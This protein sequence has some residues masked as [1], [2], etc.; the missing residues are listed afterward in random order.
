MHTTEQLRQEC[1]EWEKLR[2]QMQKM[3]QGADGNNTFYGLNLDINSTG[4]Q[5]LILILT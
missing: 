4:I 2:R 3:Q 1:D 5:S